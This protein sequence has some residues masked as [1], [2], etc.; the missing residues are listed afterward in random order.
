MNKTGKKIIHT[1]IALILVLAL[2]FPLF[3]LLNSSLQTYEQIRQWPPTWFTDLQWSNYADVLVGDQSIV[4]PLLNSLYVSTFAMIICVLVG[5]LAAYA[6]SRYRFFGN[7]TFLLLVILT[8]MFS[9]VILVTPM[10]TIFRDLGWIDSL[11][12]LVIANAATSLPMTIWLLY[13]FFSQVSITYEEAAWMDGSTRLQG[14][15]NVI[16]PISMPGII[17]AALFAFIMSWGD[18]V[19]AQ[20]FIVN[21]ELRTMS[22]ALMNFQ[23]LYKTSYELQMAASVISSIPTIIIFLIIQNYLVRGMSNQGLK[24]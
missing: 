17:T 9:P 1:L 21:P 12:G 14:I 8:Q 20:S 10:Y 19:F 11:N 6:V 4:R 23:D 13:S 2:I 24:G 7:K 15:F 22:L 5:I 16:I 18:I 3:I